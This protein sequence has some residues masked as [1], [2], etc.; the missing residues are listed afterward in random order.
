MRTASGAAMPAPF[1]VAEVIPTTCGTSK[2][3]ENTGPMN[4]TD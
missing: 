1:P 3:M 2:A 4:P